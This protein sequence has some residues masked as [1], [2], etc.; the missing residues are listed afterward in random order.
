MLMQ[1]IDRSYQ[2]RKAVSAER[3]K[4]RRETAALVEETKKT[5]ANTKR[6]IESLR[7]G[8]ETIGVEEEE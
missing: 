1:D 5:L 3:E 8:E 2:R 6:L 7:K 4:L